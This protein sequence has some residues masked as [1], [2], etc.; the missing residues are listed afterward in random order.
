MCG[1]AGIV[2]LNG[3][4][5]PEKNIVSNMLMELAHRGPDDSGLFYS[6]NCAIGNTRL[7][8]IDLETGHQPISSDND[9]YTIVYNGEIYNYKEVRRNLNV[10]SRAFKTESDTEVILKGF[11]SK[12]IEILN[13]LNG[14][15]S[16]VIWDNKNQSLLLARDHMGIKPLYYMKSREHFI[17]GSEIKAIFA[18]EICEKQVNQE[19]ISDYF[20]RQSPDYLQT[21][22]YDIY[23]LEPGTWMQIENNGNVQKGKYFSLENDWKDL[24]SI[25]NKNNNVQSFVEDKFRKSVQRQL[26][27]DVPVGISLSGGIDSSLILNFMCEK[28]TD[29][30]HAFTYTNSSRGINELENAVSMVKSIDFDINHHI[31]PVTIDDQLNYF[32]EACRLL[33][34]PISYPSSIPILL[35]SRLANEKGVK[36][37]LT[38]QGADELFLGYERYNRWIQQGLIDNQNIDDW[39]DNLYFGGGLNN[40]HHVENLTGQSRDIVIESTVYQWVFK[41]RDLTPLKRMALFDQKFRLLDLLKRDDR[42]GMGGSVETR[43]PFFDKEMVLYM[44]ALNDTWK[45]NNN[46]QKFILKEI[47]SSIL[48][49]KIVN[50]PKMGSPTDIIDWIKTPE[51]I[52]DL[53]KLVSREESFSKNFLSYDYVLKIISEQKKNY[54]LDHLS[55]CLFSLEN[56]YK[57]SFPD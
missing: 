12:G 32:S 21:M 26:V 17:F 42:M 46:I 6:S 45:I 43:V 16:F 34:A 41:H 57:T 40:V 37:L 1:I 22:Y 11:I 30:I 51:F 27:S 36:V 56:W 49:G 29:Q 15:F 5:V 10:S 31:I 23:E 54:Q 20:F 19:A 38:G 52:S 39:A 4:K 48:P 2:G 25:V 7:S 28:Y 24:V 13:E 35:I 14:I 53:M 50:A 18:S 55:W 8:I 33:D 44:N 47:A 3:A 9:R